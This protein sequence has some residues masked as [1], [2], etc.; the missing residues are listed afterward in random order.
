MCAGSVRPG[1]R[2]ATR[3]VPGFFSGC[4]G[5]WVGGWVL[6]GKGGSRN[7]PYA[8]DVFRM[9]F[10]LRA[11]KIQIP[12]SKDLW[13]KPVIY[14]YMWGYKHT[15]NETFVL[16]AAA[17]W[18][19]TVLAGVH[20]RKHSWPFTLCIFTRLHEFPFCSLSNHSCKHA[21]MQP[22]LHFDFEILMHEKCCRLTPLASIKP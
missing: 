20:Q 21:T 4:Q 12:N 18:Y 5:G 10:F 11:G 14:K 7:L 16:F 22:Q 17:G 19:T 2:L 8:P 6:A 15:H 3:P 1:D 9:C 13:T